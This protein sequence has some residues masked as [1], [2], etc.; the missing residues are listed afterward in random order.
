M[1]RP[2]LDRIADGVG[3]AD[4][5]AWLTEPAPAEPEGRM[6]LSPSTAHQEAREAG[7]EAGASCVAM[8]PGPADGAGPAGEVTGDGPKQRRRPARLS[9]PEVERAM[10]RGV[11]IHRLLQSLP[12]VP[13]ERRPDAAQK[14]L[15]RA[16]AAF[17]AA[18]RDRFLSQAL[19]VFAHSRFAP[20]FAPGSRAEV[21]I[22]GRLP[23]SGAP[24]VQVSGQ[25][26]RL[27]VT[28]QAVLIGDY[29]TNRD[30]PQSIDAAPPAYV[31]QLALYRALLARIYPD[32]AVRAVLVWT[33]IPDL[34][35]L[36]A[37]M[38]DCALV[39]FTAA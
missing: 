36:P 23:R 38:L 34:M 3:A 24:D 25:I 32:R 5:P 12:D 9:A 11:I 27:A 35:E 18:E 30:P 7:A 33:E 37:A 22:I 13:E 2:P 16:G 39:R 14:Y 8:P 6:T 15:A 10:A 21:P 31:E 1:A 19:A 20:L 26:D 28:A 29:K 4:E 17:S